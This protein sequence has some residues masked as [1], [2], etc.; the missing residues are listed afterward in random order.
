V[1]KATK[2]KINPMSDYVAVK[3]DTAETH[4]PGGLA[5][6]ASS[7][8]KPQVGTVVAIGPGALHDGKRGNMQVCVKDRVYVNKY[9][10]NEV[11]VN[12][13]TLLIIRQNDILLSLS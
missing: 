8:D 11:E 13:E 6:P 12:N 9:S 4:T 3:I 2:T 1:T 10:G 7:Q 5:L